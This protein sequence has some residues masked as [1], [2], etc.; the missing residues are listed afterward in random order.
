M[1]GR[2]YCGCLLV[3]VWTRLNEIGWI[4]VFHCS[5]NRVLRLVVA[6]LTELWWEPSWLSD[7][8]FAHFLFQLICLLDRFLTFFRHV[9][10]SIGRWLEYLVILT[11]SWFCSCSS[12]LDFPSTMWHFSIYRHAVF[13]RF[14]QTH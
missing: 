8:C 4:N 3:A 1:R 13:R 9:F 5:D 14:S 11:G 7:S 2:L 12:S 6:I 10:C